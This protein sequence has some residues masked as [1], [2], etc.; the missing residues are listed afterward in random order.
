MLFRPFF[1]FAAR[2]E[3]GCTTPRCVSDTPSTAGS[4]SSLHAA[5]FAR[6]H[7][8]ASH[9]T[10]V[11]NFQLTDDSRSVSEYRREFTPFSRSSA[12]C[13]RRLGVVE[14]HTLYRTFLLSFSCIHSRKMRDLTTSSFANVKRIILY[15]SIVY[16]INKNKELIYFNIVNCKVV[17]ECYFRFHCSKLCVHYMYILVLFYLCMRFITK[18]SRTFS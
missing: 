12:A 16:T 6:F 8:T 5:N 7:A 9:D 14:N 10:T 3:N 18:S 11:V 1:I 13:V 2:H 4:V 15:Y 17:T